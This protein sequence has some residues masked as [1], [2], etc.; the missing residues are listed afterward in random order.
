MLDAMIGSALQLYTQDIAPTARQ[1][2]DTAGDEMVP[3]TSRAPALP[4]AKTGRK[5]WK[6]NAN[7]STDCALPSYPDPL[8]VHESECTRAPLH[9]Q[10]EDSC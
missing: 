3:P 7:V 1:F 4:A 2:L 6:R 5:S 10:L 8:V 9:T